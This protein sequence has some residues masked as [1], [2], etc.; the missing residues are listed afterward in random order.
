MDWKTASSYYEAR[1]S[2]ALNVQRY[3]VNLA[4][5]PQAEVPSQLKEILLQEAEPARRQL[6][7]LRK[8]EFRIAVVG[9]EKAG[10]S[11]FINAW[12]ECDLLPAKGGRCTFTT[13]QIYSVQNDTEQKLEVQAKTEEQF[14]NLLKELEAAKAQEDIKTIRE[15]EITLQQVRREGNRTFPFTRLEDIKESLKKY[16]A[17][18]KY[19]HAVLEARLY[20]NKL[21]QAE[22]VV[23]YDVPGLDSGLAKHVDEAKEMLSD[24]DA[25]ILVQRFTSLRE[26]ELEIIKFTELGDKNITVA[27]KLFVFLSRIDSLATPEALKTHLEEAS[28]DWFKRARLPQERIVYGSAGAYLL[29]NGLAG[30]QTKLE[31]GDA[32]NIQSQLKRLTGI[33]DEEA[34]KQKGTGIPVIKDKIFNYINTERVFILKKRCEASINTILSTSEEIYNLVRKRYSENPEEAKRFEEDRRRVLFNEWWNIQWEQKKADLQKFYYSSVSNNSLD[35]LTENYANSIAKFKERYLQIVASEVQKLREEALRKK[36]IIFAAN[37]YPQFD[38]MKANFAWREDLYGD[39]SKLLAS[40]ARQLAMELK[41]EALTLVE[42]MTNLLWGSSQVKE[43]LID[44]SEEYFLSKLEN[45]LSVLFLRFARPVAEVLIRAPLNSDARDKI[46]KSLGVDIEIV[47]NYYTGE[48]AAFKVLKRYAKYGYQLLY[49]SV[50]RQQ[51][52]GVKEV[53]AAIINIV[54]ELQ[55]P[56]NDVIFEV[57]NDINA[58]EEYLRAAI[59]EAAGFES[60]CIQELKGLIDNFREKQG[61]WTGIA[62]NEWLQGNPLLLAEIPPEL[63]SQESNLEVSERLRQLSTALKQTRIPEMRSQSVLVEV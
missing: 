24:C 14:I 16:V 56:Q 36:D 18:E 27:D 48:E 59:F 8:R 29:L 15:N 4:N 50:T 51:V 34:L 37:S 47:D 33:I 40:I 45:S 1:L 38:R 58:F 23:F 63:R 46:A 9:L 43:R 7:R 31:I 49:N 6:E 32:H 57:E 25:V 26:K 39:I 53:P 28:Q 41:D 13:T 61:T 19:A 22:G 17:D 42:Y 2:E 3:A 62:L 30:E 21:A 55:S 12:L 10:K 44:K 52:L 54:S 35:N 5:L 60:Y 20:T 11:T